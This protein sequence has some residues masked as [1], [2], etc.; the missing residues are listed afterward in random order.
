MPEFAEIIRMLATNLII[1]YA[2]LYGE[3]LRKN[4]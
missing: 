4:A 1:L 3:G 2:L